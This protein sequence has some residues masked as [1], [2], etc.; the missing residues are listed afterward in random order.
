MAAF[1][2]HFW[3]AFDVHDR[4]LDVTLVFVKHLQLGRNIFNDNNIIIVGIKSSTN[5]CSLSGV[6]RLMYDEAFFDDVTE[7]VLHFL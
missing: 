7:K 5:P 2:L 6:Q 4:F 1:V 3:E